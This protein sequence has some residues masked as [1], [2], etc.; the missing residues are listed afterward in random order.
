MPICQRPDRNLPSYTII[1]ALYREAAITRKLIS[2]LDAIQYP[3]A[4]LEVLIVIEADDHET[5]EALAALDLPGH[6]KIIRAPPGF[7]RTK[8]R[9][10]NVALP[11]ARGE[12]TVVFDAEDEPD[13]DQ[14]RIAAAFFA[15][16]PSRVACLQAR[17]TID[18]MR[19]TWLT[20]MFTIE[21][22]TLFDVF[23][24]GLA[25]L[26]SPILLGG[27]S[28]HFR[29]AVLQK[30][31]GWDAWNV[32]EDADLGIRLSRMGYEVADLP[33]STL[34][35]APAT[36]AKWMKQRTRW[37]KGYM[38]TCISHSRTARRTR[39]AAWPLARLWSGDGDVRYCAQRSWVSVLYR[40]R[41]RSLVA[42]ARIIR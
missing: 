8:P 4:K 33:S 18:N 29:T 16:L 21:Y 42:A 28:N 23:N 1:A 2:A 39:D 38:Q 20:R 5:R 27:T 9:A 17:L 3:R 31:C 30:I 41:R 10:L 7:P 19:D 12:F 37:M 24:P 15:K 14:L 36:L 6:M 22:A 13:G 35:E 26:G 25:S 34:E 11:L 32:T 40:I